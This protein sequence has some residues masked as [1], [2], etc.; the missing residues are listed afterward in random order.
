MGLVLDSMTKIPA[1]RMKVELRIYLKSLHKELE[2]LHL[3]VP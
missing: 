1:M 2:N 3:F